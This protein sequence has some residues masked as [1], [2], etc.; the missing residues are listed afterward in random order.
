MDLLHKTFLPVMSLVLCATSQKVNLRKQK[1]LVSTKKN[2]ELCD[3]HLVLSDSKEKRNYISPSFTGLCS[4]CSISNESWRRVFQDGRATFRIQNL[5]KVVTLWCQRSYWAEYWTNKIP[6]PQP[7][8]PYPASKG[9][10]FHLEIK[11]FIL[12]YSTKK[13]TGNYCKRRDK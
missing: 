2:N 1:H 8:S 11:E 7:L 10:H 6:L 13:Y 3:A 5:R 12:M 4:H 9:L